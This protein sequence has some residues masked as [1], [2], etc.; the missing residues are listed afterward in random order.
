[1]S[2]PGVH[3]FTVQASR[4]AYVGTVMAL[5]VDEVQMPGGATGTREV[6]EHYGAV[7]VLAIDDANEVVLIHQYRHPMG[8]R[9]WELPAGLLDV[10]DEEPLTAA[11]RELAEE[12]GIAASHWSVLVDLAVSP[13]FTD[14]S[15]RV[16]LAEGLSRVERAAGEHEEADLV[17]HRV[18]L[19][20]AVAQVL[21]GEIVN[22]S[23]VAGLL[24]LAVLRAGAVLPRNT[25]APWTDRPR[26]FGA[27]KR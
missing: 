15:V 13:G 1:M 26:A 14:E 17:V 23:A 21:S 4:T 27:R 7:A 10:P 3:E 11:Q 5:R 25:A 24:A 9:L 8:R 22:T 2:E 18:P 19:D 20:D 16:Y 12:V 6:I